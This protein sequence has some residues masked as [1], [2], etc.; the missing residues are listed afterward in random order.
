M[1][2]DCVRQAALL[3]TPRASAQHLAL[4]W[5]RRRL[6]Q[7]VEQLVAG[8]IDGLDPHQ[9]VTH[10]WRAQRRWSVLPAGG[11]AVSISVSVEHVAS[12]GSSFGG[13]SIEPDASMPGSATSSER[14]ARPDWE[15]GLLLELWTLLTQRGYTVSEVKTDWR[16]TGLQVRA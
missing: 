11:G 3:R 10:G 9:G 12:A 4:L 2:M 7:D 16:L 5:K 8:H 13:D 1:S 14:V 6:R 15:Y